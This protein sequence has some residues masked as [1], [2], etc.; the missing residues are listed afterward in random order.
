MR[1]AEAALG[2]IPPA[3]AWALALLL[4]LLLT[5]VITDWRQRRIPNAL[6][7]V[8]A[9][10]AAVQQTLLPMGVHPAASAHSGTPGL[11]SGAGAGLIMLLAAGTLWRLKWWG[12]GDAKWMA[13]LAAHSGPALVAPALLLTALFGGV[14][15]LCWKA[16]GRTDRMPYALAIAAG[17]LALIGALATAPFLTRSTVH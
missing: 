8:G 16:L 13:V 1:D 9:A 12:A 15:A 10:S 2:M 5:A 6:V 17:H 14:L 11:L 3:S 4:T 7:A